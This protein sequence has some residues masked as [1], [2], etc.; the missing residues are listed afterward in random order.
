[1]MWTAPLLILGLLFA[2]ALARVVLQRRYP[3]DANELIDTI[4]TLL[5]QTQCAQCGYPG[6]RPYAEALATQQAPINLCPPGG[7]ALF[8]ALAELLDQSHLQPPQT[9]APMLA[10]IDEA[11]CIGCTLCLPPCPVDAIVG[12]QGLMHTVIAQE[13]TGCEL[14]IPACPVDC[15]NLVNAPPLPIP[16]PRPAARTSTTATAEITQK[17]C[18][19]CSRCDPACPEGLPAH[20]LLQLVQGDAPNKW[21]HLE[22]QNLAGCIECGLCDHVCPSEIPLASLFHDAKTTLAHRQHDAAEKRRLK[23]RYDAHSARLEAAAK[24]AASKR[25]DRL[26]QGRSWQ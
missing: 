11:A 7:D 8:Q 21:T 6:C 17:A 1:M 26:A 14:C 13:C 16:K 4:D 18:I 9:P 2:F 3:E 20:Q 19:K 10:V 24:Q 12:A 25:K 5:P 23:A 15:I 22:N